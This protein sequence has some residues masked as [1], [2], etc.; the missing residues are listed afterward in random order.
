MRDTHTRRSEDKKI[1]LYVYLNV[2]CKDGDGADDD[3]D[4]GDDYIVCHKMPLPL[5]SWMAATKYRRHHHY[6]RLTV[7]Q[8]KRSRRDWVKLPNPM[9]RRKLKQLN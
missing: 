6:N 4:N 3:D 2:Y 7:D 8:F 1:I 5:Y 9:R